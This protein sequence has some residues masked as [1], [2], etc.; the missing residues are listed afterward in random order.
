LE[1]RVSIAVAVFVVFFL[2][3]YGAYWAF[4]VRPEEQSL[5]IV[6]RRLLPRKNAKSQQQLLKQQ[7]ALSAVG[8]FD[9]LLRKS[10]A[11]VL[12]LKSLI[13]QAGANVTVGTVLAAAG[14]L[15]LVAFI[16]VGRATG[17]YILGIPVALLAGSIPFIV[18]NRL[19]TL[20]L[21]KLE[22]QFPEALDLITRAMRAGHAFTTGLDMVAT[23]LPSPVREEFRLLY[24][25]QN[26][27]MSMPDALKVFASRIPLLDARFFVTAVLIQREAGGNLAEV[28]D[29]L[30]GVIRD[31]FRVKRQMR[32]VSAHGRI[33]GWVLVCLPPVLGIILMGINKEHRE[34]MFGETLGIQMMVGAAILQSIGALIIRKIINVPY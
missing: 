18:L 6:R 16:L 1:D 34:L 10:E 3:I 9:K 4:V 2:G 11:R 31:R 7:R 33:T 13:E 25:Q 17:W 26:Y 30:S 28:L 27:G 12:P 15:G 29:N 5:G 21:R 24:D 14:L 8:A 22:E 20:R 32:V 23:E 19:R